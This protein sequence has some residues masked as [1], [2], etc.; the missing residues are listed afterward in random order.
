[1]WPNNI[2]LIDGF[3]IATPGVKDN[4]IVQ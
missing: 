2:S 1:M 4:V 3:D